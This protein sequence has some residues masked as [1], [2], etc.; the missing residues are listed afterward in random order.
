MSIPKP[1]QTAL[2][3]MLLKIPP[4]V[5]KIADEHSVMDEHW[6][7]VLEALPADAFDPTL[8]IE[9]NGEPWLFEFM[10][11]KEGPD[12]VYTFLVNRYGQSILQSRNLIGNTVLEHLYAE[13]LRREKTPS[14]SYRRSSDEIP[15]RLMAQI[16]QLSSLDDLRLPQDGQSSAGSTWLGRMTALKGAQLPERYGKVWPDQVLLE[17]G[18]N[19]NHAINGV[20]IAESI[21]DKNRLKLFLDHGL[22]VKTLAGNPLDPQQTLED[23]FHL[24]ADLDEVM[25]A[26]MGT[27]L[28]MADVPDASFSPGFSANIVT[29]Q[30][31][32]VTQ[33]LLRQPHWPQ[34]ENSVG[35]PA[36]WLAL[37]QASSALTLLRQPKNQAATIEALNH[38]DSQG[39]SGWFHWLTQLGGTGD[40]F[41]NDENRYW[42]EKNM[43]ATDLQTPQGE[44]LYAQAYALKKDMDKVM[45][46][47]KISHSDPWALKFYSFTPETKELCRGLCGQSQEA[48]W[49]NENSQRR[50]AKTVLLD[51]AKKL[52]ADPTAG[53]LDFFTLEK[54]QGDVSQL[55]PE[56]VGSLAVVDYVRRISQI[57]AYS[58]L[59]EPLQ[60]MSSEV[61]SRFNGRPVLADST[62][63]HVIQKAIHAR[64]EQKLTE[65]PMEP[66]RSEK[67]KDQAFGIRK[68]RLKATRQALTQTQPMWRH[69]MSLCIPDAKL[70][71]NRRVRHRP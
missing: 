50:L 47:N 4:V 55:H 41:S 68:S 49:G 19:A 5:K 65:L 16:I 23:L 67:E 64:I 52:H 56:L 15:M 29:G 18:A 63:A 69:F 30:Q 9:E 45:G 14:A 39:R 11:K 46:G 53:T 34:L 2:G 10:A 35:V 3:R 7:S 71:E 12:R 21:Q 17:F 25:V 44:G 70:D 27:P 28:P 1:L 26:K 6:K 13:S 40:T 37:R 31:A 33:S 22:N 59:T 42:A 38:R 60:A 58:A 51:L 61:F 20:P 54:T 62:A 24:R 32:Q 43:A 57:V 8:P 48:W 36:I 66:I